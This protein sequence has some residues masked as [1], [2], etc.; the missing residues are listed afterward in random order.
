M[1]RIPTGPDV[2]NSRGSLP[3]T[4]LDSATRRIWAFPSVGA[5]KAK[6]QAPETR[7]LASGQPDPS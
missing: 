1:I 6:A 2:M 7:S 4:P 3:P 5:P